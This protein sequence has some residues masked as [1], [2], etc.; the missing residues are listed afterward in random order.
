MLLT[1]EVITGENI[2]SKYYPTK[3]PCKGCTRRV[4]GCHCSCEDYKT[5]QK[6]GKEIPKQP[7]CK[8]EKVIKAIRYK[9]KRK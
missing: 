5:W 3:N 6:S 4:V 2:M 7:Y 1:S 9:D 8:T